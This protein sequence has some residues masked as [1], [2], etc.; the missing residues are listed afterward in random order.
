MAFRSAVG[1]R[2]GKTRGASAERHC[3]QQ[4]GFKRGVQRIALQQ[5]D[6]ASG[7]S[8]M[9]RNIAPVLLRK[10]ITP[11]VV[12]FNVVGPVIGAENCRPFCGP[13]FGALPEAKPSRTLPKVSFVRSS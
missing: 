9:Q 5:E 4:A 2:M 13:G 12:S 6:E 7:E 10:G 11:H 1:L 8:G 3:P